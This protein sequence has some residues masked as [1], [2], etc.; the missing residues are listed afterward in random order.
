MVEE[1]PVYGYYFNAA[2]SSVHFVVITG[3]DVSEGLIYINNPW[4]MSGSQTFAQFLYG[5]Y[6]NNS[7]TLFMPLRY[8][9]PVI[10]EEK[11]QWEKL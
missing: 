5:F 2:S 3:V 4:G 7:A 11:P 9:Y 6:G 10:Q 8:V 1:G